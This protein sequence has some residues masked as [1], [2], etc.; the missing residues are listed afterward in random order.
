MDQPVTPAKIIPA[1]IIS[2]IDELNNQ[3]WKVHITQPKLGLE[4]SIQAKDLSE[5]IITKA[6]LLMLSG[7]W[8]L[9]IAISQTWRQRYLFLLRR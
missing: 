5:K 6:D 1:E 7:I 4:L 2:K 3:A 8:E 9:A